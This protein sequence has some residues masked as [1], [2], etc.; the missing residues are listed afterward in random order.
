LTDKGTFPILKYWKSEYAINPHHWKG[1]S[2]MPIV[3]TYQRA[4][5]SKKIDPYPVEV[6]RRIDRPTTLINDD[7]VQRV[8]ERE[9]GFMRCRRGDF[10]P[11]YQKEVNRFIQKFPLSGA[12]SW[13]AVNL[14][15]MVEGIVSKHKAP[16]PDDPEVLARHIK[17]TAIS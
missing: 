17:Q 11:H 1:V 6:L 3:T 13:M 4:F 10:G 14:K 5:N 16:L 9:S 8:D 2:Y 12:L 15:D 7:E